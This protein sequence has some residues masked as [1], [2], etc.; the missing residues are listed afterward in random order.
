MNVLQAWLLVG[1]PGLILVASLFVGHSRIRAYAGYAVLAALVGIFLTVDGGAISA[2][3]IGLAAVGLV[4]TAQGAEES[5][6]PEHHETRD[7]FTHAA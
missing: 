3:V 6:E 7:R 2:G 4:A 1:V 5:T